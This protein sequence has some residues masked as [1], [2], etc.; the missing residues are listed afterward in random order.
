ML[1]GTDDTVFWEGFNAVVPRL[2][3]QFKPDVIVSQLGV[4]TFRNDP[5]A[6][7]EFTT[8]GFS[9]VISFLTKHAERWVAL[10]GGGYNV[11]NV[12]RAWTIAW[13]IMNDTE[14]PEDLP[15]SM[16]ESVM[17]AGHDSRKL[18]DPEHQSRRQAQ[19]AQHMS[20]V[21]RYLEKNVFPDIS[22]PR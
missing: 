4:D 5:L 14:L 15:D 7:L 18:R 12:A 6:S 8:N 17:K 10:G 16:V 13:G 2:M 11:S 1:P 22:K 19:C 21:I 9:K 3:E 20:E